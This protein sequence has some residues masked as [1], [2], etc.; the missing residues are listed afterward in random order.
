MLQGEDFK[1]TVVCKNKHG[2]VVPAT[3]VTVAASPTTLGTVVVVADGSAGVFTAAVDQVGPV[4]LMA[5]AAGVP[6]PAY[7]LTVE[8]DVVV[9]TVE[10]VPTV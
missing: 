7:P 8:A 2:V 1:F 4:S 6:S 9:S 5:T 10:I 3:D